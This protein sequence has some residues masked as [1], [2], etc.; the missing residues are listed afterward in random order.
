MSEEAI[1]P[2][3][4][5]ILSIYGDNRNNI[6]SNRIV[7]IGDRMPGR[8]GRGSSTKKSTSRQSDRQDEREEVKFENVGEPIQVDKPSG[9]NFIDI[10]R[11]QS[12]GK[13]S[14][15]VTA[16]WFQVK[17]GFYGRDD[18]PAYPK[19]NTEYF[20]MPTF[21]PSMLA[22][23]VLAM[24]SL[25]DEEEFEEYQKVLEEAEKD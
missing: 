20:K 16:D 21:P 1:S 23:I 10:S 9:N 6:S 25:L 24:E 14:G 12:V 5:L 19:K 3:T 15:K 13:E 22:D 8:R 11:T 17:P 4:A 18:K 2:L 7:W